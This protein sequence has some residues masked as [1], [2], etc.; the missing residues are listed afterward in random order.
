MLVDFYLEFSLADQ[1]VCGEILHG[2][3]EDLH[4]EV[5]PLGEGGEDAFVKLVE[6]RHEQ[7]ED[8]PW[9]C[10]SEVAAI[11]RVAVTMVVLFHQPAFGLGAPEIYHNGFIAPVTELLDDDK[12]IVCRIFRDYHHRNFVKTFNSFLLAGIV[13]LRCF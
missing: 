9:R 7:G 2:M 1:F 11:E 6:A 8:V 13:W 12:I 5:P 10:D 3:H 4:G